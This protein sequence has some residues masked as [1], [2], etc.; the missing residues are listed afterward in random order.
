[1]FSRWD[2]DLRY[3][4]GEGDPLAGFGMFGA[5]QGVVSSMGSSGRIGWVLEGLVA[6][7]RIFNLLPAFSWTGD[8]GLLEDC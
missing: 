6:A 1:M 8:G 2:R 5:S 7:V 4:L 3:K